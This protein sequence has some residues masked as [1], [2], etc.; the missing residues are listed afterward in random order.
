MPD[1]ARELP[2]PDLSTTPAV[3]SPAPDFALSDQFGVPW[4]LS[5]LVATRPVLLVFYPLAF[6]RVCTGE[7]GALRNALQGRAA[8]FHDAQVLAISV[9]S[10]FTLRAFDEAEGLG[11]P[12]LSDFWPHGEVAR[13]YG[14]FDAQAGFA[15]RGTFLV[16]VG[17]TV[18][19]SVLHEPGESRALTDYLAAAAALEDGARGL[20]PPGRLG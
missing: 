9:D 6:S 8:D 19:W 1:P 17:G 10:P 12:L 18:R 7:L 2:A 3:G 20:R 4:R 14:V 11:L 16:G 13:S 15:W 5:R